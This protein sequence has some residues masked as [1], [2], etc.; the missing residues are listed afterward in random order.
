LFLEYYNVLTDYD[1]DISSL[2][3]DNKV[4]ATGISDFTDHLEV[5]KKNGEIKIVDTAREAQERGSIGR[6]VIGYAV[7]GDHMVII[8]PDFMLNKAAGMSNYNNTKGP[9]IGQQGS[10][11][12]F[13]FINNGWSMD[14]N[15]KQKGVIF[16]ELTKEKY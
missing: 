6:F 8:A 1:Y 10:L 5:A 15:W 11:P 4:G 13:M 16:I 2:L 14:S 3:V 7:S 12:G 9:Y